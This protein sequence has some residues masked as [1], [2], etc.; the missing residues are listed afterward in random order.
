[1]C[2]DRQTV[3]T[4]LVAP[5]GA[6][7]EALRAVLQSIPEIHIVRAVPGCLSAAQAIGGFAPDLVVFSGQIPSEEIVAFMGDPVR[8]SP[9]PRVVVLATSNGQAQRLLEAGAFAVLM[10]W[11]SAQRLRAVIRGH[12]SENRVSGQGP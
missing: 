11:D 7:E 8:V 3:S 9:V 4:L 10:P 6:T 2:R 12:L 1:M 5:P